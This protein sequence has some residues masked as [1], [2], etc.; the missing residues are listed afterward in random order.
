MRKQQSVNPEPIL[1]QATDDPLPPLPPLTAEE[2]AAIGARARERQEY[3]NQV[4][5][6]LRHDAQSCARSMCH[7]PLF[8]KPDEWEDI[9][10]RSLDDYRSGRS[11]MTHLGADRLIDPPLTGMLLAIRR[12]LLE[13]MNEASMADYVVI[14]M[15]VMAFASAMRIQLSPFKVL[16][17]IGRL[18]SY[19]GRPNQKAAEVQTKYIIVG[20]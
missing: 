16:P 4:H 18:L 3:W 19:A 1:V 7:S 13:E 15:A 2:V 9:V 6:A 8:G 11:L 12:G 17:V 14:D 10:G 20:A 5:T